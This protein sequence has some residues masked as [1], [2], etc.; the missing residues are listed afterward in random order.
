MGLKTDASNWM[1]KEQ[2][3]EDPVTGLTFQF[4]SVPDDLDAPFRLKIFGDLPYGN[5]EFLF[6]QDGKEAGAG[7]AL[8]GLCKPTWLVNT[9][10]LG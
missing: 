9:D 1:I 8:T 2:I 5:R 7:V 3:I 6:T 10:E 4:E